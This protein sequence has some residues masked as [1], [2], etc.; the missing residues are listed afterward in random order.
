MT[1]DDPKIEHNSRFSGITDDVEHTIFG[2]KNPNFR[3][4][5]TPKMPL[6][7]ALFVAALENSSDVSNCNKFDLRTHSKL[8]QTNASQEKHGPPSTSL[9]LYF[10]RTLHF[11]SK[12][13]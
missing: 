7:A 3:A 6:M 8:K 1:P 12:M 2:R 4:F 11:V 13:N 5:F 10:M 9:A